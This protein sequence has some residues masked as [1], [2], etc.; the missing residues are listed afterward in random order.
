M[1]EV[2]SNL[3]KLIPFGNITMSETDGGL[4]IVCPDETGFAVFPTA[5]AI[6]A[7]IELTAKT[8]SKN[9]RIKFGSGQVILNSIAGELR[10]QDPILGT[11][12][13]IDG[14]GNFPV[15][16]FFRISWIL[17]TG[18]MLLLVDGEVR[19]FSEEEPYM[20]LL[21]EGISKRPELLAS[22]CSERGSVV[23]LKEWNVSEWN[24]E[25]DNVSPLELLLDKSSACTIRCEAPN[26]RTNL[27]HLMPVNGDWSEDSTGLIGIGS[28]DCF[29]LSSTDAADFI[30]ESDVCIDNG[31]AAAL[32]FRSAPNASGFY[33]A[34]IDVS[35]YVKLWRPGKDIKISHT[36]IKRNTFYRLK[37]MVSGDI[38]KLFLDGRM[39]IDV[40]DGTYQNGYF[41]LN[42]FY[43][44][45]LFQNV[46]YSEI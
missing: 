23:T 6:P 5:V 46:H 19:A 25:S 36:E 37:V 4:A 32:V 38:I 33:C 7:R 21:R 30:Y 13:E 15:N 12:Y 27:G 45:A 26:L 35:G 41:G 40:Y 9:I 22:I 39:M 3:D 8:N 31:A 16:E 43:A 29:I 28:G 20:K 10:I 18:Y 44:T 42:V 1:H 2:R 24:R 11:S 17:D 14:K 34:A